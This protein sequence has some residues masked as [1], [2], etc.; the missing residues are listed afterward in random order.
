MSE[1]EAAAYHLEQIEIFAETAADMVSAITMNYTEEAIGIANSAKRFAIPVAISFTVETDGNLPTG[2]TLRCAIERVDAATR[3]YPC[4]YMLN[5]AHP[6]HFEHVLPADERWAARIRGI[7]ANASRMSHAEL[8]EAPEVD[9]G[10][11]VQL[12]LDYA[13]L[14]RR[15][16]GLNVMGGCCGT[17]NRHLEQIAMA[18][19]LPSAA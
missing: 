18:V 5:C 19:L 12:G 4:Y 3:A 8:N 13:R 15:M 17:D 14:K 10:D 1:G 16:P 9:I 7:R 11:P 2:E 6:T